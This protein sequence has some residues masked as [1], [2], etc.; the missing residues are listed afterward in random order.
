MTSYWENLMW[1]TLTKMSWDYIDQLT[2]D[3][4]ADLMQNHN[5]VDLEMF[6]IKN[7]FKY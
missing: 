2:F 3:C 1:M 5:D 4:E 6:C 7:L